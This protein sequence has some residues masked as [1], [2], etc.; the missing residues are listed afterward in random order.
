MRVEAAEWGV[1]PAVAEILFA[2]PLVGGVLLLVAAL[3][4]KFFVYLT[5]EDSLFEWVTVTGWLLAI[6]FVALAAAALWRRGW[7]SA[8]AMFALLA[9]GCFLVLGEELSWGQR[10]LGIDTPEPVRARNEQGDLSAHN[11]SILHVPYRLGMVAM[12]IYGSL[13]VY[14]VRNRLRSLWPE[15][16]MLFLPPL[17]L[18]ST[19]LIWVAYRGLRLFWLN[20]PKIYLWGYGEWP[21]LTLPYVMAVFGYLVWQRMLPAR[22]TARAEAACAMTPSQTGNAASSKS[23]A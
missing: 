9:L 16:A 6:P 14:A 4:E 5:R 13:L 19:F 18:T 3:H 1:R 17:F 12:G 2:L 23:R 15:G 21:E 8:G 7:R 11:L 22:G 10:L 20:E